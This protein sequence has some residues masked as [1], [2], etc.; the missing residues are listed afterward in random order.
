VRFGD[1]EVTFKVRRDSAQSEQR[2]GGALPVIRLAGEIETSFVEGSCC[3]QIAGVVGAVAEQAEGLG[4]Q[5]RRGVVGPRQD[6]L[7]PPLPLAEMA[8]D[9]P[10]AAEVHRQAQA[11]QD[12]ATLERPGQGGS[13]IG[14]LAGEESEGIRL[15]GTVELRLGPLR[16]GENGGCMPSSDPLFLATRRQPVEGELLDRFEHAKARLAAVLIDPTQNAFVEQ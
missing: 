3:R 13:Q 1:R 6:P 12:F 8:A 7:Q 9:V 4:A 2:F 15:P 10:E 5:R 16:Q 11:H 14:V